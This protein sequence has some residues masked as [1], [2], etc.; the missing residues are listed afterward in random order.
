MRAGRHFA[1][2][3]PCG[4]TGA[5]RLSGG[6]ASLPQRPTL[7]ALPQLDPPDLPGKG[8][9]QIIH[10][11]DLPR[12]RVGRVMLAHEEGRSRGPAFRRARGHRRA[13]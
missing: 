6:A 4:R 9:G 2:R 11:L 1:R 7:G 5:V 13:R 10:E 12:I 8:L 3:A